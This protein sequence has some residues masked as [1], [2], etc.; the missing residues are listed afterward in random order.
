MCFGRGFSLGVVFLRMD[1]DYASFHRCFD[2]SEFVLVISIL[3]QDHR[4]SNEFLAKKK[5][6]IHTH[7]QSSHVRMV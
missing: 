4:F 7:P 2:A 1:V 6:Q 3:A 5:K